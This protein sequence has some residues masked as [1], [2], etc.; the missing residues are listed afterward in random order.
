[1][2]SK[3]RMMHGKSDGPQ[4]GSEGLMHNRGNKN[5]GSPEYG[6]LDWIG[7]AI[8]GPPACCLQETHLQHV[9]S[10]KN[11]SN[12]THLYFF[13]GS[14]KGVPHRTAFFLGAKHLEAEIS[15]QR[16]SRDPLALSNFARQ[17][18]TSQPPAWVRDLPLS[19]PTVSAQG[20]TVPSGQPKRQ[21]AAPLEGQQGERRRQCHLTWRSVQGRGVVATSCVLHQGFGGVPGSDQPQPG[22]NLGR[23]GLAALRPEPR[24]P[25]ATSAERRG[26]EAC[27]QPP[28][29][30][31]REIRNLLLLSAFLPF[32]KSP[33][34]I[35]LLKLGLCL[36]LHSKVKYDPLLIKTLTWF[37]F[38]LK[39]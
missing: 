26:C 24:L 30:G 25:A 9:L 4:R 23:S 19:S 18:L 16:T 32:S 6:L 14:T 1:M 20:E 37:S 39:L 38:A 13:D 7:K 31:A 12:Q 10:S 27:S 15:T 3:G 33:P 35:Q 5:R 8:S 36:S 29:G 21:A 22:Q 2:A 17:T 28:G 11:T 34:V